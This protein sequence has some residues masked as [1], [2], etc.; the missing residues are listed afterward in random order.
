MTSDLAV[1]F[2]AE[3][4]RRPDLIPFGG[5]IVV[6]L[7]GGSDS[8]ALLH[9][10]V[11]MRE[12]W[13]LVLQAA[14]FDHGLRATSEAEARVVAGWAATLDVQCHIG[15]ADGPLAPAQAALRDARYAYLMSLCAECGADRLALGHQEDDQAETVLF[16]IMRGTG[17]PGL[18]GIPVRRG[19]IVRPLLP[20]ARA[21]I[22]RYLEEREIPFLDDASNADPRW[23]RSRIRFRVLPALEATCGPDFRGRLLAL[24]AAAGNAGRLL[25]CIAGHA[26]SEALLS[27]RP[28]TGD[29]THDFDRRKLLRW[30]TE[31]RALVLRRAARRLGVSLTRGGTRAGV[32]FISRG[33]SGAGVSLGGGLELRREYDLLTLLREMPGEGADLEVSIPEPAA[34]VGSLT[35]AGKSYRVRWRPDGVADTSGDRIAVRIARGHYPMRLRGWRPGDRIRLR[36]GSRKLK[37]LFGDLRIPRSERGQI[38][39]LVDCLGRV[40]WVA[41]V[42]VGVPPGNVEIE[43]PV[44]HIELSDG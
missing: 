15:R 32:E 17:V 4:K 41:G 22:L 29:R 5:N 1:R 26:E 30:S 6:A 7:S 36:Q 40:L 37:K 13:G 43:E 14:H 27:C 23:A 28:A 39:V 18:A 3:L 24:S 8:V 35:L 11:G 34:G 9:L 2:R 10:L 38:A 25:E 31:I 42:A 16:R 19:R 44:L 12:A 20:F 21:E 33:R